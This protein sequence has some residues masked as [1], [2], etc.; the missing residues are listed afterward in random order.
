M[1]KPI[2]KSRVSDVAIQQIKQLITSG[3]L[4]PGDALP[5]REKTDGATACQP[6]SG[7]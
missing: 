6:R 2:K 4:K 7:P 1:L 3:R 5:V